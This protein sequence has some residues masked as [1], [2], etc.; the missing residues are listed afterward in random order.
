MSVCPNGHRSES[1]DYCDQCG[2]VLVG[3]SGQAAAPQLSSARA[4]ASRPHCQ[5]CG[6]ALDGRFCEYCGHDS[7]SS[8]SVTK[9]PVGATVSS[10]WTVIAVADRTYFDAVQAMSGPDAGLVS[11]PL[12]CPERRFPLRGDRALVGRRHPRRGVD[13]EI[14]LTG[15]P[16]DLGV[17]HTHALLLAQPEGT[18]AV[19]DLGSANGTYVNDDHTAPI[20]A[21]TATPI[22]HGDRLHVGAWTTLTLRFDSG[23]QR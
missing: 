1:D 12:Y 16:E 6:E 10:S 3:Q 15:P 4:Q 21:N 22:G 8:G 13:P 2:A 11:F 19:V 17:S 18:W 14:D 9:P 7:A 23:E 5:A 20:K